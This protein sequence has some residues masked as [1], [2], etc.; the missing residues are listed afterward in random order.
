MRDADVQAPRVL[1]YGEFCTCARLVRSVLHRVEIIP[2]D[3]EGFKSR[4]PL[5]VK[6]N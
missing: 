4:L 5:P 3:R 1:H 2:C 6:K